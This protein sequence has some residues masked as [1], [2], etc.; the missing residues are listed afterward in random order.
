M[1]LLVITSLVI[2]V[3]IFYRKN[4][5]ELTRA[6]LSLSVTSQL[7][8]DESILLKRTSLILTIIFNLSAAVVAWQYGS[9]LMQKLP[10]ALNDFGRFLM[11]AFL[12]SLIYSL[13]YLILKLAGLIFE[14]DAEMD[15]YVFNIFLSNNLFGMVLFPVA[16]LLFLY[17]HLSDSRFVFI[18]IVTIAAAF[19][20][21]RIL[22]GIL[23][24]MASPDRSPVYL[25]LYICALE[26]APLLV[27]IKV[28]TQQ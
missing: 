7:V 6:F 17:P 10:F 12:I 22:R 4:I 15:A 13:K 5:S 24:G 18:G 20:L 16:A 19:F 2:I 9:V 25:F 14:T 1:V 27:L 26:F 11:F 28:V 21:Y 8:R 23:I 3:R